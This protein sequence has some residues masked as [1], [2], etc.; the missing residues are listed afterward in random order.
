MSK[1]IDQNTQLQ[2]QLNVANKQYYDDLLVYVR[3]HSMNKNEQ[4][5]RENFV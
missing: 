2:K 3:L 5:T 1:L 4:Q